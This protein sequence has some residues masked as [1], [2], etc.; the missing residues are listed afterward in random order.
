MGGEGGKGA[1]R[2][3]FYSYDNCLV[4]YEDGIKWR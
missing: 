3:G 2:L 4:A 1:R